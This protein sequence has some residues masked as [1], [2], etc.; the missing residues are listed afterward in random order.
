MRLSEIYDFLNKTAPFDMQLP[1]DNSGILIDNGKEDIKSILLCLDVTNDTVEQAKAN[2]CELIISHHPIIFGGLKSVEFNSPVY[3]AVNSSVAVI[4]AHTNLDIARGG[5]NDSLCDALGLRETESVMCDGAPI[6]RM[7]KIQKQDAE[8]FAA[9][10]KRTLCSDNVRL[11][12]GCVQAHKIAVCS[13]AGGDYI[14]EAVKNGCDTFVTGEA[15]HHEY[16]LA[17]QYNINLITAG[18]FETERP[19]LYALCEKLLKAFPKHTFC[20]AYEEC[21]YKTVI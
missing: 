20:I 8:D 11:S 12:K 13:G 15:K 19:V 5:V 16:L 7:G 18:H 14:T 6:M 17:G 1:W 21:P 3:N 9:F 2:G 4:C 10:C